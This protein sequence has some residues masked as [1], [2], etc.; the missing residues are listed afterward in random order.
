MK[1]HTGHDH[2]YIQDIVHLHF[3]ALFPAAI[4]SSARLH[5]EGGID[6]VMIS[7]QTKQALEGWEEDSK[8]F[9]EEELA[10]E[11]RMHSHA[12][13]CRK[14]TAPARL[15]IARLESSLPPSVAVSYKKDSDCW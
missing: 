15:T 1:L 11:D 4:I 13:I 7:K 5:R 3:T 14:P 6:L 9:V 2:N 10:I 8:S 12:G